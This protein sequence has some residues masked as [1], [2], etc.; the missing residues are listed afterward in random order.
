MLKI[1]YLGQVIDAKDQKPDPER[2]SVIRKYL[3]QQILQ[4]YKRSEAKQTITKY[5][6]I[7]C[8]IFVPY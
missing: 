5:V 1:K 8:M 6:G 7:I 4:N 3:P 2:S